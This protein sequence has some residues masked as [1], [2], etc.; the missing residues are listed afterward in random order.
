MPVRV[1]T[2]S[3][4]DIPPDLV[5]ELDITVVPVLLRFGEE[6]YR[7]GIDM[8]KEEFYRRLVASPV[9]PTTAAPSMDAFV[10]IYAELA[11][12]SDEIVAVMLSS[13]LSGVY[14]VALQAA[15]LIA[16]SCRVTVVDSGWAV[17][18][19]GFIVIEAARAARAG[20]G[21]EE[22]L[23]VIERTKGRVD[24][25]AVLGTLEYLKRGGR[26]GRAQALLGSMLHIQPMVT[27][28]GGVVEPV[29]R[30]HSRTRAIEALYEHVASF[31][32]ID[33]LAV[34]EAGCPEDAEQLIGLLSRIYPRE[35]ILRSPTTPVIGAHTGPGLLLVAI[36]G[37][38]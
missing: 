15:R 32:R 36:H 22:V 5:R 7:D 17:M 35:R 13:R 20:A 34:E 38:R 29:G 10:R 3:V 12:Q 37:D 14:N 23:E 18:A 33:G 25:R 27:L 8:S 1:V 28:R 2:D 31:S 16:D 21:L 24:M 11:R 30:V 26:I 4:A 6:T 19:E 9:M